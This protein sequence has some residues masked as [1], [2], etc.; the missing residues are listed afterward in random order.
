MG[1]IDKIVN[2]FEGEILENER[3]INAPMNTKILR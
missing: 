2:E 3:D 1:I